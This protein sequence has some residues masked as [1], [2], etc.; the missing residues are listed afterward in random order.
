MKQ[1]GVIF[2]GFLVFALLSFYL[3]PN[4]TQSHIKNFKKSI[5]TM[6]ER[7]S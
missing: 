2:L 6:S 3:N 7:V 1:L 4:L 5:N